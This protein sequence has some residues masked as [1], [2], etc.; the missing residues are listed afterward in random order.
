MQAVI[1]THY[2]PPD[3]LQ[4]KE[5]AGPD[6]GANE[7]LVKIHATTVNRTDCATIRAKPFFARVITGLLKPKKQIPGSEFAGTVEAVGAGVTSLQVGDR[8]FGFYDQG[9]Q[10]HA[11]FLSIA[12][13]KVTTIPGDI[14][15]AQAAASSEGAHYALNFINKVLLHLFEINRY[16]VKQKFGYSC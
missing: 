14:S 11:Q 9:A 6:P 10:S 4:L 15:Y 16:M 3:V 2:G 13:D 8:V 7:V 12:E 1:Y 5:V